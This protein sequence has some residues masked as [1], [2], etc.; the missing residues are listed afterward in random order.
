MNLTDY[1]N[2]IDEIDRILL[3]TL[4][5]RMR[6]AEEIAKFKVNNGL[7]INDPDREAELLGK[8]EEASAPD[9]AAYNKALFEVI[10][11]MSK[12]HQRKTVGNIK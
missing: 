2:R 1:R 12:D 7:P 9:M 10:I 5:E 4:E 8:I 6:I 11:D 3:N